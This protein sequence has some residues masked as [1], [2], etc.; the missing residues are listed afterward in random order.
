MYDAWAALVFSCI[1][2]YPCV[3]SVVAPLLDVSE[4]ILM[5]GQPAWSD[6]Q[7]NGQ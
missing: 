4:Y 6:P 3:C 1:L 5:S 2:V 7:S